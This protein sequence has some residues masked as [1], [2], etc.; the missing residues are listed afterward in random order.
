MLINTPLL[1]AELP[2]LQDRHSLTSYQLEISLRYRQL[3]TVDNV[4]RNLPEVRLQ[5]DKPNLL[6]DPLTLL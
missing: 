4:L 2:C 5:N 1:N 6:L 3:D